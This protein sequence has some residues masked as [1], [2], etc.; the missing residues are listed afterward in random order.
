[1]FKLTNKISVILNHKKHPLRSRSGLLAIYKK[2]CVVEFPIW[3][4]IL[5]W[6]IVASTSIMRKAELNLL[7]KKQN[8]YTYQIEM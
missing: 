5:Q 6:Y 3:T 1:M 2:K 7:M 4:K 8:A